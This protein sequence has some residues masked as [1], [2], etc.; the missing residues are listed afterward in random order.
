M[1]IYVLFMFGV[2][3]VIPLKAILTLTYL[4]T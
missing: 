4:L 3:N 1:C 2:H